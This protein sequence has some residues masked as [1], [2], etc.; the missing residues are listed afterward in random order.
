[1]IEMAMKRLYWTVPAFLLACLAVLGWTSIK[2]VWAGP[3]VALDAAHGGS[4]AG[5]KAG[6]ETEK[7][8]NL[9]FVKALQ[10]ALAG[11]DVNV[12]VVRKGDDTI[13][14]G[15]RQS[16]LNTS[17]ISAA[18]I[19]HVDRDKTGT[20][21][22]PLL[23]VEPPTRSDGMGGGE[24]PRWG[25]ISLYQFRNSLKLAKA[26]ASSLEIA[27]VL[28]TL[29]DS[30]GLGGETPSTDGRVFCLPH[31]NLR[32]LTVPSVVL[33]P[34]FLTSKSDLAKF[35]KPEAMEDFAAKVAKGLANYFQVSQ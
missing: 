11:F 23:V 29:S 17:G 20:Q 30:R 34:L 16:T 19:V 12:I 14:P 9:K 15:K 25:F 13:D 10:K 5:L 28:N 31:Q 26:I 8:W 35:S 6:S 24:I 1:V 33:T 4:D 3:A 7:D 27:P 18:V 22:G 32:Y 2:P 21:N